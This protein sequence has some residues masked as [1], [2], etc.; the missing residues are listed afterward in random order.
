MLQNSFGLE[1][2]QDGERDRSRSP[3]CGPTSLAQS[4]PGPGVEAGRGDDPPGADVPQILGNFEGD[5]VLDE[6]LRAA[7]GS[8]VG[9]VPGA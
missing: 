9:F 5:A 6:T 1:R 2:K 7:I 3:S 4:C 8:Q